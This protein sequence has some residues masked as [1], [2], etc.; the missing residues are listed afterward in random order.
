MVKNKLGK[1]NIIKICTY[2]GI[3]V[4]SKERVCFDPFLCQLH[5]GTHHPRHATSRTIEYSRKW[6]SML[7]TEYSVPTKKNGSLYKTNVSI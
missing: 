4:I 6:N 2:H 1:G 3:P 7:M 5:F